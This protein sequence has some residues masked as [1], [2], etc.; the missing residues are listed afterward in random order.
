MVGVNGK[1]ALHTPAYNCFFLS[2]H[3]AGCVLQDI[4][5]AVSNG[6]YEIDWQ[7]ME[8]RVKG[9]KMLIFCN[10]HNPTGRV[11]TREELQRVDEICNRHDVFVMCD[12]I[13]CELTFPGIAYTPYATVATGSNWCVCT[14]CTKSF[15]LAGL[16]I[17]NIIVPDPAIRQHLAAAF[18]NNRVGDLTAM[19][20]EALMA[21]YNESEDWLEQLREYVHNNYEWMCLYIEQNM[22][23]LKVTRMQ[24]T[25]LSWVDIRGTGMTA[26]TLCRRLVEEQHV[27]FNP[28]EMY[29]D[30]NY[31]RVNMACP[32]STLQEAM[33]RFNTFLH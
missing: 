10:P 21:A 1:V 20:I 23:M 19:S 31:I 24:G 5:M 12:E 8:E 30:G 13:H 14:S 33:Q 3:N 16:P 9:C 7:V 2:P 22:P 17:A 18:E 25:Y 6:Q 11:W 29:G 26:D 4:P 28:G 15:N 27:L 32:K